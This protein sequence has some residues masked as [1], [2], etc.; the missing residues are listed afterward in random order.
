MKQLIKQFNNVF[1]NKT[2]LGIMSALMVNR[3]ID[4]NTLKKLLGV[5]DG[6]LSSNM[7]VLERTGFVRVRKKI[8]G[9]KTNTS[10]SVTAAGERAFREHLEALESLIH[11]IDR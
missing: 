11:E 7:S 10:Y 2:R 8:V 3:S 5:T 9:K 1:A 6:N 4:F